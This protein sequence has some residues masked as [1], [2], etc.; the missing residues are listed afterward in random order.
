MKTH[1][2]LMLMLLAQTAFGQAA[3]VQPKGDSL[4]VLE[5]DIVTDLFALGTTPLQHLTQ[6]TQPKP[7]IEKQPVRNLHDNTRI[8]TAFRLAFDKDIFIALKS[9]DG[10]NKVIHA[11]V[12]STLFSTRHGVRVG[13]TKDEVTKTLAVYKLASI[14]KYLVLRDPATSHYVILY[15]KGDV[16]VFVEYFAPAR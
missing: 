13:M 16:L 5:K 1:P 12:E 6:G 8:D 9:F 3:V 14:P 11:D 10:S 7:A 4:V 15:F 2:L